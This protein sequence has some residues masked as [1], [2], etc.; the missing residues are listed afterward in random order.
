MTISDENNPFFGQNLTQEQAGAILRAG[1]LSGS[2]RDAIASARADYQLYTGRGNDLRASD[3]RLQMLQAQKQSN[4]ENNSGSLFSDTIAVRIAEANSEM[5]RFG[6]TLGNLTFDSVQQ[7]LKDVV[8]AMADGTKSM[9]DALMGFVGGIANAVSNALLERA[10]KQVTTAVFSMLG[11]DDIAE[12]KYRGG[13]IQG[14][15][16]GGSTSKAPAMLTAGEY[17][18]RKKIVDRLGT[19]S[20]NKM[21]KTGTIDNSLSELYSKPNEDSFDM[22]TEGSASIPPICQ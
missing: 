11:M 17:V 9:K 4:L 6:E 1:E 14:Y 18:V 2:N 16:S 20:L 3:A 19:S 8:T 5:E 15:A 22:S 13:L 10:T 21:N 12:G 7:G